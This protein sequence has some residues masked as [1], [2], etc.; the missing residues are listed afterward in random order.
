VLIAL[1]IYVSLHYFAVP[2]VAMILGL[3]ALGAGAFAESLYEIFASF[4]SSRG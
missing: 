1:A 3:L 4:Q 2:L